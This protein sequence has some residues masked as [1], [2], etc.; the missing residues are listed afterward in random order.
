MRLFRISGAQKEAARNIFAKEGFSPEWREAL[1][2]VFQGVHRGNTRL[3]GCFFL[4]NI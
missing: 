1:F 2:L 4:L 3:L